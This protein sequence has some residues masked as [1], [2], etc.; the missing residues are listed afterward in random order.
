MA[1]TDLS[2]SCVLKGEALAGQRLA[3]KGRQELGD[4]VRQKEA[5]SK[6]FSKSV[7]SSAKLFVLY[8][9]GR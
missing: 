3:D 2:H 1:V 9:T 7:F 8:R 6:L 4:W 5:L